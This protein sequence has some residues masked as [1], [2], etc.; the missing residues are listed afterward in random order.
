MKFHHPLAA[1]LLLAGSVVAADTT[2][3]VVLTSGQRSGQHLKWSDGPGKISYLYEYNDRGRGPRIIVQ[4]STTGEGLV[5]DRRAEGHDYFKSKV[6][7]TFSLHDGKAAWKNHIEDEQRPAAARILYSPLNSVPAEIELALKVLHKTTGH[8][9]DMLPSG[10]L[11]ATHVKNH[12]T[13]LDGLVIELELYAFTGSGGP[14]S[15]LW[16]TPKKEFFASIS[17]WSSTIPEGHEDLVPELKSLQ[18]EIEEDYFIEQAAKLTEKPLGAVAI[19]NVAVFDPIAG[20]VTKGRTVLMENGLITKVGK[21]KKVKV[22]PTATVIDGAGKT[23]LPGLWD[24]H[25]HFD[26]T[27]GVYHLAAG[28]TNIKDMANSLDLP[29]TIKKVNNGDLLGP[30]I[31]I[32]SGFIDFAGPFAGP[33]GKIVKTLEEGLEAVD[34]YAGK[35]YQQVKLY[36]SIP[37]DWVKPLATRA[38]EKGLKVCGHVP[39]FMTAERA[40]RDGYDQ[41]IHLNMIMLNFLGDSIDTRSMLRFVR[42]AE[43]SRNIDLSS[44]AVKNFIALLKERNTIIDPTIGIFED[45]KSVV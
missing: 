30:E 13:K 19:K 7:E 21:A 35:G 34:F 22:P 29:E 39:S 26:K 45:R 37:V 23:L 16:F 4:I 5:T 38:H 12:N 44:A 6:D 17:S 9:L 15:Y 28:V 33:T 43:R 24:N 25:T 8:T 32:M 3:Y 20:K 1:L 41:I 10:K 11:K 31:S 18:D 42:V 27:Q 14:P 2:R 36:S 40:I